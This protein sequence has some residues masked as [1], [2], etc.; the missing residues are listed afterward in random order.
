MLTWLRDHDIEAKTRIS[1]WFLIDMPK[2]TIGLVMDHSGA[3][4]LSW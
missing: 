2:N 1:I 3:Q 4:W